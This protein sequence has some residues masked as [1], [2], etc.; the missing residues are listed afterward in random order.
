[1]SIRRRGDNDGPQTLRPGDIVQVCIKQRY[2]KLTVF[3]V[4][5]SPDSE[6]RQEVE[7]SAKGLGSFRFTWHGGHLCV[8]HG[9]GKNFYFVRRGDQ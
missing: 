2:Y 7:A 8:G 5:P 4:K 9:H 1:M 6:Y 3:S